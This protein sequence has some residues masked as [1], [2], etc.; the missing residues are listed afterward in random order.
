[1]STSES[2]E[3]VAGQKKEDK[4]KVKGSPSQKP[5]ARKSYFTR[6]R[7]PGS[8]RSGSHGAY[9]D[10][11]YDTGTGRSNSGR[12]RQRTVSEGGTKVSISIGAAEPGA[13]IDNVQSTIPPS[14]D[15]KLADSLAAK[16]PSSIQ[17]SSKA[18]EAK[19][20]SIT[21]PPVPGKSITIP[22]PSSKRPSPGKSPSSRR[23]RSSPSISA[24]SSSSINSSAY[25]IK[26]PRTGNP[27]DA[28]WRAAHFIY[29]QRQTET[30]DSSTSSATTSAAAGSTTTNYV[31]YEGE[32]NFGKNLRDGRGVCLYNNG[33]IYEG[34][35]KRNKE[36]GAGT[37]TT[38]DRKRIIYTG[39]WERGKMVRF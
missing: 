23:P 38:G 5:P 14:G 10:D 27:Q 33:T 28:R 18:T 19:S 11:I 13:Q 36:H 20:E 29:F 6:K 4:E 7:P 12:K 17:E 39:D 31:V 35:W 1:M 15:V 34:E 30:T 24:R 9:D 16:V 21:T 26:I 22:L 2:A 32:M 37:L 25:Q 3:T 8:W